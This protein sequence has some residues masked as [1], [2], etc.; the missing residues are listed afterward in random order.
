MCEINKDMNNKIRYTAGA[1]VKPH[2]VTDN[3]MRMLNNSTCQRLQLTK[4]H[5]KNDAKSN[6]GSEKL[7]GRT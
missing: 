2:L 3:L 7:W 1:M 6:V 4:C 5:I